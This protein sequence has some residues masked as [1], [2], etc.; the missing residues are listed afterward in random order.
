MQFIGR[1]AAYTG[2]A[3]LQV[4]LLQRSCQKKL[5]LY[6]EAVFLSLKAGSNQS[7]R[8]CRTFGALSK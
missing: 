7:L 3:L 2:P 1:D 6:I 4:M 5:L 8:I